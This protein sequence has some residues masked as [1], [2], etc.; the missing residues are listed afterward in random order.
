MDILTFL[1]SNTTTVVRKN[2][3]KKAFV[4]TFIFLAT[5]SFAKGAYAATDLR[6]ITTEELQELFNGEKPDSIVEVYKG[7][8]FPLN[9]LTKGEILKI[10]E[11]KEPIMVE[12]LQTFY[13]KS[14]MKGAVLFSI[15]Q[16]NWK[17]FEQLFTGNISCMIRKDEDNITKINFENEL[18]LR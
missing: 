11:V 3:M 5:L 8:I 10:H 17:T 16:K 2:T 9:L 4:I 18:H 12:V 1:T 7:S 15:D 6:D 13:V 14:E